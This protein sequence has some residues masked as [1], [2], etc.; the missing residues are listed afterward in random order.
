MTEAFTLF[1]DPE[2]LDLIKVLKKAPTTVLFS[3]IVNPFGPTMVVVAA[4]GD[5]R[6]GERLPLYMID[7]GPFTHTCVEVGWAD[8]SVPLSPDSFRSLHSLFGDMACP[9]VALATSV[10][11]EADAERVV[12]E[13]LASFPNARGT[14]ASVRKYLGNPWKRVE[15]ETNSALDELANEEPK[16]SLAFWKK[17]PRIED[18]W[19]R[20]FAKLLLSDRHLEAERKA[21][22]FAWEGALELR[23]SFNG[24]QLPDEAVTVDAAAQLMMFLSEPCIGGDAF[25]K[26]RGR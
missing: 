20:Q 24:G 15:K 16:R 23:Q 26:V 14:Y 19:A 8:T 10:L 17:P 22:L 13:W 4:D 21:L 25:L 12:E 18:D 3:A 7:L 6:S 11:G 2:T 9:T 5:L 1:E